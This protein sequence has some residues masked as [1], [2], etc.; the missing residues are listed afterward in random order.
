MYVP[1]AF[2]QH[3]LT[4]LQQ[5]VERYSFATLITQHE[6]GGL[7]ASH[8]PLM[9]VRDGSSYGQLWGHLARGNN[10]WQSIVGEALAIFSGPHAYISPRWYEA[11]HVVPTWN[12]VAVHAYGPVELMTDRGEFR[13]LLRR[14]IEVY[15]EGNSQPWTLERSGDAIDQLLAGIVGFRIPITRLDGKWKLSQNHAMER[16]EKIV[17]ALEAQADESA[18]AIA[19]LMRKNLETFRA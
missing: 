10:Q 12:Y 17:A 16:Q 9:L 7:R 18:R 3:D 8:I 11:E 19:D 13:E 5:F 6:E 2:A 14:T 1:P 4:L 15:E